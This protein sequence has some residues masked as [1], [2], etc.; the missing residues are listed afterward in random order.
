M[1]RFRQIVPIVNRLPA[2]LKPFKI[3][4]YLDDPGSSFATTGKETVPIAAIKTN[5]PVAR[6]GF[7]S[8]FISQYVGNKTIEE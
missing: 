2:V 6:F 7:H 5:S 1:N 4:A 3:A 8:I